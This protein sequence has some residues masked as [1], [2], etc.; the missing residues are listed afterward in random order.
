MKKG[1]TL[2]LTI[3]LLFTMSAVNTTAVSFTDTEGTKCETAVGVLAALGI[4]EGKSEGVYEP[5][6]LLTRAEMATIILRAMDMDGVTFGWN[7]FTDVPASHWAYAN[8]AAAY[9]LGIINGTSATTFEPDKSVTYEQAVKMV[10]A[11]L[12]YTVQADVLG[13]YPSGYLSKAAQLDLLR[14]VT[15]GGEMTR[16]N[17]AIL[18]YNALDTELFLQYTFGEGAYDFESTETKTLLSYYLKV[19]KWIGEITATPMA[20]F[21]T[22]LE[23]RKLLGDEVKVGAQIMKKGETNAQ[24]M[25]GIRSD[26]YAK[27]EDGSEIPV[28]LAIVP[29]ASVEIMDVRAQDIQSKTDTA[30]F[31]YLDAAGKEQEVSIAGAT[32]IYNGRQETMTNNLIVPEIGTVRLVAEGGNVD[33]VMVWEYENHI[34][35]NVLS[36][37]NKV[38]FAGSGTPSTIIDLSDN[39]LPTVMTDA[40][41]NGVTLDSLMQ[42]DVLSIAESL[43][44]NTSRV[45]RIY[46]SNSQITGEITEIISGTD[47][48]VIGEDVYSVAAPLT[49]SDVKLGQNAAYYLDF[50]GAIAAMDTSYDTSRIYGWLQN[51]EKTKGL[52][53]KPQLKIYTQTGEWKVF[54]LEETV[55]FNGQGRDSASLLDAT[56]AEA[57]IWGDDVA[58]SFV[59]I[60]GTVVPQLISYKTNE[61]GLITEIE[62]AVNKTSL[63][64]KDEEKFGD[65]FSMDIYQNDVKQV[66]AFNGEKEGYMDDASYVDGGLQYLDGVLFSR[67]Y[68]NK[69]TI[70]F[71]IPKDPAVERGYSVGA[72]NVQG[73]AM[74][75]Y[76]SWGCLSYYDIDDSNF[77]KVMVMRNDLMYGDSEEDTTVITAYPTASVPAA[78]ITKIS[79]VLSEDGEPMQVLKLVNWSGQ[80]INAILTDSLEYCL[81]KAANANLT[82]DL[83]W[84]TEKDED[85]TKIRG[86]YKY[87]TNKH[88]YRK[89]LFMDPADLT[90]GDVIQYSVDSENKLTMVSVAHR[91]NYSG[92][93]E[94]SVSSGEI[95]LQGTRDNFYRGGNFSL[96]G[97]VIKVLKS[98]ILVSTNIGDIFGDDSQ[99]DATRMLPTIGNFFIWNSEKQALTQCTATDF[100]PEDYIWA[101]WDTSDQEMVI[102]YR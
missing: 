12:G 47:E 89:E 81:Y 21:G 91:A 86:D 46:R 40:N 52:N 66:R 36:T 50:T 72:A 63:L 79:T 26:I 78:I 14:G 96:C 29:R 57:N 16:G 20:Q 5:N 32:F 41:G 3:V 65:E 4:V 92:N 7:I 10:V 87:I 44:S 48:V 67:V 23:G 68:A 22:A 70:L 39:T 1:L 83:A 18:L 19:E 97:T 59:A 8:I 56:R 76:R 95:L 24:D 85:G 13:G 102:A 33:L 93:V 55:R 74:M 25:L 62:T 75:E 82:E 77:C 69:N 53:G 15:Q 37:E 90:V 9:Q 17:M 35:E 31:V 34:V 84:Y 98:G 49:I 11:A 99:L 58:P 27:R 71:K 60:N 101:F 30:E 80:E 2:L 61:A 94:F 100:L 45:R 6:S 51:A 28:I 38:Y 88:Q 43:P 54:D 73:L 64:K 42:W